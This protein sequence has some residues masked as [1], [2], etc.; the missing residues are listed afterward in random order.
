[1]NAKKLYFFTYDIDNNEVDVLDKL[2]EIGEVCSCLSN[3]Y[4][5]STSKTD[6]DIF[7]TLKSEFDAGNGR[8]V[9]IQVKMEN[10][11]GWI[12][13]DTIDWLKNK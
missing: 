4:F 7:D 8:F 10:M 11:N 2:N 1:M 3:G 9:I 13:T 5:I 12:S 6:E